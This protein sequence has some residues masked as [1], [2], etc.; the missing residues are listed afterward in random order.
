MTTSPRHEIASILSDSLRMFQ[1]RRQ[2]RRSRA[3][4]G[5]AAAST[6]IPQQTQATAGP[7]RP[8]MPDDVPRIFGPAGFVEMEG[9][10]IPVM[11]DPAKLQ[12]LCDGLATAY[13]VPPTAFIAGFPPFVAA[14]APRAAQ[15]NQPPAPSPVADK[16]VEPVTEEP[17][18]T[19][20]SPQATPPTPAPQQP[21]PETPAAVPPSS[22]S[23][24]PASVSDPLPGCIEEVLARRADEEAARIGALLH[25]HELRMAEQAATAARQ[26]AALLREVMDHHAKQHEEQAARHAQVIRDLLREHQTQLDERAAAAAIRETQLIGTLLREHRDAL[27]EVH[28]A[29]RRDLE[30]I[31]EYHRNELKAV[32]ARPTGAD[33]G[34][35]GTLRDLL[36][37]HAKIQHAAHQAAMAETTE[38]GTAV[39]GIGEAVAKLTVQLSERCTDLSWLPP[40]SFVPSIPETKGPSPLQPPALEVSPSPPCLPPTTQAQGARA[41]A[42]RLEHERR[43]I[44]DLMDEVR[45]DEDVGDAQPE[46]DATELRSPGRSPPEAVH[47]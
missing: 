46:D 15:G 38:L 7:P 29:H 18:S 1:Q 30:E 44:D 40:P 17:A 43:R 19:P 41:A 34:S 27:A 3:A 25:E 28:E 5:Y 31:H 45:D 39:A 11:D 13:G 14:N 2:L 21:T 24:P 36:A 16:P 9:R 23:P 26:Q 22:S 42:Q 6:V 32:Q 20:V 47:G 35:V 37:E 33:S 4:D 10:A 8:G 12:A